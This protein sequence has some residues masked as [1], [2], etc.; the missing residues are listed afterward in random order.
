MNAKYWPWTILLALT[1]LLMV[2][3]GAAPMTIGI[4][5]PQGQSLASA[6]AAEALRQNLAIQLKSQ[7][8]EAVLLSASANNLADQE[9]QA[10]HCSYVLYTHVTQA[11]LNNGIGGGF[12]KM[13]ALLTGP[14][15]FVV[16]PGD[17][18]TLEYRLIPVGSTNVIKAESFNDKAA[19]DGQVSD[20]SVAQLTRSVA[21]AAQANPSG[22]AGPDSSGHSSPF[23]GL[24]GRHTASRSISQ[25]NAPSTT[26]DCA[27]LT[28]MP[29][30]PMTAEA[31]EKLK[32]A[33]QTYT[34]AA[35][36]PSA[37]RPGDDQ[38][39]CTQINEELKQQQITAPDKTKVAEAQKTMGE[40][41]TLMVKEHKKM[42][43]MQAK[44]QM[45]VNAA[46]AADRATELAT[47]GLVQGRALQA[48]EKALD[49]EHRANNERVV[50][51]D[52][53]TFSKLNGQTADLGSDMAAQMQSN[54]RLARLVQL[55]NSKHC[56]GGG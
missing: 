49:A 31:C 3:A 39:T 50:K 35:A 17:V 41:Q 22:S 25:G 29:N 36:D 8:V 56:K 54:P 28:N 46:S 15:A 51:E 20:A 23:G 47:G 5:L 4:V 19:P 2:Q 6:E 30:A 21:T 27:Q 44:D 34:T 43:E 32:G 11:K 13:K 10:K 18:L 1:P 12:S 42:L 7:S 24:F 14:S 37:A 26:M 38:M 45:A 53:P 48:T 52:T 55:A 9:A 33:Q 16:K 40:A